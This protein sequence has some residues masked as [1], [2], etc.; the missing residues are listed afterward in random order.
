MLG[1]APASKQQSYFVDQ[2]APSWL[3]I[4]DGQGAV[5]AEMARGASLELARQFAA[6]PD[7]LD[8]AKEALSAIKWLCSQC[9]ES[10]DAECYDPD[11]TVHESVACIEAAIA[12][13][14]GSAKDGEGEG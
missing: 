7:L 10:Y 11:C 12:K 8:A 6:G 14:E 2:P 1:P 4:R 13:A 3:L 9:E 5:V